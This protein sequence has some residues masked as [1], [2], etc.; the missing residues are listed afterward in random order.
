MF[1]KGEGGYTKY[2][3]FVARERQKEARGGS[4]EDVTSEP[5][6]RERL[7]FNRC[8]RRVGL[9]HRAAEEVAGQSGV[10][11]PWGVSR[12]AGWGVRPSA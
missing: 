9:Q 8:G 6:F 5:D 7:D 1:P 4:N 12:Q 10:S 11:W 2:S 3:D